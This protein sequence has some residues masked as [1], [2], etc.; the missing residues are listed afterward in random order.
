[1]LPQGFIRI[2]DS[3]LSVEAISVDPLNYSFRIPKVQ[4]AFDW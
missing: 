3:R 4:L 2:G 1:M